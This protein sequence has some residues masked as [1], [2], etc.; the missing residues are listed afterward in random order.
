MVLGK[1]ARNKPGKG[2]R[3]GIDRPKS[4]L[5]VLAEDPAESRA[6]RVDKDQVADVQQALGIVY[7]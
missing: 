6:G 1:E 3:V 4:L 7:R 5:L 2:M